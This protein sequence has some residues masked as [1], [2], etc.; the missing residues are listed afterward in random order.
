MKL[1]DFSLSQLM[2][3]VMTT[4]DNK[5]FAHYIFMD[6]EFFLPTATGMPLRIA[7]SGTFTPGIKGGLNLA[8]DMVIVFNVLSS[9]LTLICVMFLG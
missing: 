9:V 6:N 3:A 8:R 5:I 2:K 7:V 1:M 4:T